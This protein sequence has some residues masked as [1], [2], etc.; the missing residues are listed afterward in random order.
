MPIYNLTDSQLL[1]SIS[2]Y[3]S[4]TDS[5]DSIYHLTPCAKQHFPNLWANFR[6]FPPKKLPSFLSSQQTWLLRYITR[7]TEKQWIVAEAYCLAKLA[8]I[9]SSITNG[10]SR[11]AASRLRRI[12]EDIGYSTTSA[13]KRWTN[14]AENFVLRANTLV[15]G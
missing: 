2:R 10:S 3:I 12:H 7:I 11:T 15:R 4:L 5:K 14:L 6:C 13:L 1:P 9:C 8:S